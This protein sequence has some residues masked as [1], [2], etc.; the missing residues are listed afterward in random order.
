MN[1][2]PAGANANAVAADGMSGPWP[3]GAKVIPEKVDASPAPA[4]PPATVVAGPSVA[5]APSPA[6]QAPSTGPQTVP[7]KKMPETNGMAAAREIGGLGS[8]GQDLRPVSAGGGGE[9]LVG[10]PTPAPASGQ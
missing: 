7:V 3:E 10:T 1:P 8:A 6:Q 2:S 9:V 4:A 5:L